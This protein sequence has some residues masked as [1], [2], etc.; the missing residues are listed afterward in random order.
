MINGKVS[1]SV[2]NVRPVGNAG[3][4]GGQVASVER[5]TTTQTAKI[6]SIEVARQPDHNTEL[7]VR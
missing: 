2:V 4:G 7:K 5:Q 3:S 6:D 1:A